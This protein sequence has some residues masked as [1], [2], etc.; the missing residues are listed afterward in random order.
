MMKI[1]LLITFL[2]CFISVYAGYNPDYIFESGAVDI[3]ISDSVVE[4]IF[5]DDNIENSPV[6]N[7]VDSISERNV[8]DSVN[9]E[10]GIFDSTDVGY[11]SNL[12]NTRRFYQKIDRLTS[13]RLYKMTYIGVPLIVGGIIERRADMYFRRLRNDY[14]PYFNH[15]VDDYIQYVPAAVLLGMKSFGVKSRSS[16]GR[17]LASDAFS[18]ALMAG[19]VNTLK[20]TT[21]ETRPDGSNSH[22]FH[23]GH[24]ATAFMTATMLTKEY[25]HISPWIGIG[26]YTIASATGLMRIANNKHWLSDVLTGAGIGILSTEIGYFIGDLTFRDKGINKFADKDKYDIKDKPS[27]VG[28]YLGVDIPLSSYVVSEGIDFLTSSGSS[29]GLESAYFFNP[30]IG[31]GGRF[32]VSSSYVIVNNSNAEDKTMDMISF[33]VGSYF[34]YP[35]TPHWLI[36]SKFLF[37]YLYYPTLKFSNITVAKR[38]T[39]CFG[40]GVSLTFRAR[41]NF[42]MRF[43][44]DYDLMPSQNHYTKEWMNTLTCGAVASVT[45]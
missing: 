30:Y 38:H 3:S 33:S 40:T 13:S 6:E 11:N 5:T 12:R 23:S 18:I 2:Y 36:G 26:A 8:V 1:Y 14:L 17:M 34:S 28:L 22:S 37:G 41:E 25:G 32:K 43:F 4:S 31:V 19:V 27:F 44:I 9:V 29:A 24:T 42:G 21:Q 10:N 15:H 20:N 39:I 45:F 16:W 35:V 7:N